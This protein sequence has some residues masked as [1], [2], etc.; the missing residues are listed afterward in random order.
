MRG[1]RVILQ[2]T[3]RGGPN[4]CLYFLSCT[5]WNEEFLYDLNKWAKHQLT[6]F[7]SSTADKPWRLTWWTRAPSACVPQPWVE[8]ARGLCRHS[9]SPPW[10]ALSTLPRCA[11]VRSCVSA[12]SRV[13]SWLW[14]KHH[15]RP[16]SIPT[17]LHA[18]K[19]FVGVMNEFYVPFLM[20]SCFLTDS[21]CL[22]RFSSF[23]TCCWNIKNGFRWG[24]L[25]SQTL[26]V[27]AINSPVA[28]AGRHSAAW[29]A[30]LD[31]ELSAKYKQTTDCDQRL[32]N[33]LDHFFV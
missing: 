25:K 27:W 23:K 19:G 21:S 17:S 22:R 3:T 9:P 2:S 26:D 24:A 16:V 1:S 8:S 14:K 10:P 15:A 5:V 13:L 4:L 7:N 32:F 33:L 12:P 20:A 30:Y 31:T 29:P 28:E 11:E 18:L 6:A